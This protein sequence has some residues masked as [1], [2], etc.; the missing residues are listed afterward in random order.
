MA[1]QNT[2]DARRY[3]VFRLENDEYGIEIDKISTIIEK[4]MDITRVPKQIR[5]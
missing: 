3:L 4:D 1:D 2:T 5:A